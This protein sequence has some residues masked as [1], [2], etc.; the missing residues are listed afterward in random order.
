MG[1]FDDIKRIVDSNTG[2]DVGERTVELKSISFEQCSRN[3]YLE[4]LP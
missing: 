3:E 1:V 4:S 2:T